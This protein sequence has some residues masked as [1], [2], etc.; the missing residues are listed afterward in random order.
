MHGLF[1]ENAVN[2]AVFLL[3]TLPY[4][5]LIQYC[6]AIDSKLLTT[7][8]STNPDGKKKNVIE[9]AIG[10]NIISFACMGSGGGGL[11]FCWMNMEQ[12]IMIGRI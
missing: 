3:G 11:I 5:L 2:Q 9:K 10:K 1:C 7:Q 8:Y 4:R 6:W 12:A